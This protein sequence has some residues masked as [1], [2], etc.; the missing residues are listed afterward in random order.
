LNR[1]I[2]YSQ[3]RGKK[4]P[5]IS[6]AWFCDLPEIFGKHQGKELSDRS[7]KKKNKRKG[8]KKRGKAS[9]SRR[10]IKILSFSLM[11]HNNQ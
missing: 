5:D 10:K 6:S 1:Q 2:S 8:M 11:N 4:F 3:K 9:Y 7:F